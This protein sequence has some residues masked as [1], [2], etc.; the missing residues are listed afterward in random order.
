MKKMSSF[1]FFTCVI[2]VLQVHFTYSVNEKI[3]NLQEVVVQAQQALVKTISKTESV[4]KAATIAINKAQEQLKV[5][6]ITSVEAAKIIGKQTYRID[7]AKRALKREA[8]NAA[9]R[10]IQSD[11]EAGYLNHFSAGMYNLGVRALAPF[12]AGYGYT[13]EEKEIAQAVIVQLEKQLKIITQQYKSR[14]AQIAKNPQKAVKIRNIFEL[15]AQHIY[16]ALY[17]QKIITGEV[18]S[19]NR[20]LFW[21][22]VATAG[23]I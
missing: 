17:E 8:Q 2:S 21:G 5:G 15:E 13:E 10:V 7:A 16:N 22:A 11:S 18:M 19:T 3:E 20:K 4:E 6:L 14:A 9:E 1:I 12:R 23:A